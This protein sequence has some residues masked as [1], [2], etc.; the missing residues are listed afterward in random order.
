MSNT[1]SASSV[2]AVSKTDDAPDS[3]PLSDLIARAQLASERMSVQN[4][5]RA[6][7]K[8]MAIA[9]VAQARL[10]ADLAE[11]QADKPRIVLP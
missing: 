9:L 5:N 2:I 10:I 11:Q 1:I 3:S 6:L 7:L 4:A 8:D